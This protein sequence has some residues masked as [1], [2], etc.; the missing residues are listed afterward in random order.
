M[1]LS[2]PAADWRHAR[3]RSQRDRRRRRRRRIAAVLALLTAS[4][5]GAVAVLLATAAVPPRAGAVPHDGFRARLLTLAHQTR[6]R[7]HRRRTSIEN[8]GIDRVLKRTPV[9]AGGGGGVREVALTFDD[10]PG[11]Y[12]PKV[13]DVLRRE[14]VPATFFV[15]GQMLGDFHASL[16]AEERDGFTL[17]D[18]TENHPLMARLAERAQT[19]QIADAAGGLRLRGAPNPRLFRPPYRSFSATTIAALRPFRMLMVLWSVDSRDYTRPGV[20]AIVRN[21]LSAVRPGAIVLMHD[22]GGE[23]TQTVEAL[24]YIIRALRRR[25]F[26]LVSVPRL[27][28]DDPPRRGQRLPGASSG[29]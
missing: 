29:G 20:A 7:P 21:V 22:A 18:H 27:L 6:R 1:S 8:R 13:L 24:P 9:I 2:S 15:V 17:G 25:H 12:T 4:A 3:Q 23:R 16:S 26:R 10:G 19:G 5:A 11:P 28:R 14:H